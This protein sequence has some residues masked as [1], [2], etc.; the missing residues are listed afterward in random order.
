MNDFT[1]TEQDPMQE[2][3]NALHRITELEQLLAD[4]RSHSIEI[5]IELENYKL[6]DDEMRLGIDELEGALV[7]YDR[8]F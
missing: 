1:A 4:E 6:K 8:Q 5:E 2:Y 7:E 3:A